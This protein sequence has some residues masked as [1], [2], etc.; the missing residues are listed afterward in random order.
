MTSMSIL[1]GAYTVRVYPWSRV[2]GWHWVVYD[3]AGVAVDSGT[4]RTADDC[5]ARGRAAA[6][7]HV[8][9]VVGQR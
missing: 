5:R 6:V 9:E 1:G 7:R 3:A 2:D 4:G 8:M